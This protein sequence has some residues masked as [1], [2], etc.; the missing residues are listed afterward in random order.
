VAAGK[1]ENYIT[2]ELGKRVSEGDLEHAI[3]QEG[4]G[5]AARS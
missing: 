2:D 4:Q 1:T 5:D 3:K